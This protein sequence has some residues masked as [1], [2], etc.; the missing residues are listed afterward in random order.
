M[1]ETSGSTLPFKKSSSQS[2]SG[3]VVK[4]LL[5]IMGEPRGLMCGEKVVFVHPSM[6][7]GNTGM[8]G[9]TS[10]GSIRLLMATQSTITW[11]RIIPVAAP[12]RI[13]QVEII[14]I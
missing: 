11:L 10:G 1:G 2:V 3:V 7:V 13:K 14:C 4:E 8:P 6:E 12:Y 9:L 5:M